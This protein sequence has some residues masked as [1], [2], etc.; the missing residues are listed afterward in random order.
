MTADTRAGVQE[1][2]GGAMAQSSAARN[3]GATTTSHAE[4][5]DGQNGR[6][7]RRRRSLPALRRPDGDTRAQQRR[8]QASAPAVLLEAMVPL[9]EQELQDH[10]GHA[11]TVQGEAWAKSRTG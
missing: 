8:R 11:G 10:A 5:W 2:P 1:R 4:K 6:H 3:T 9:H 7:S